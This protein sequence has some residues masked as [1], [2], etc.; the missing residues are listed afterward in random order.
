MYI[1]KLIVLA[2]L[3]V[4]HPS[5]SFAT[6]TDELIEVHSMTT[7][8]INA[9]ATP[10]QE[11]KLVFNAETKKVNVFLDGVWK[12]LLFAFSTDVHLKIAN[13]TLTVLDNESVITFDS[14]SDVIL[15]IPAGLS[16]GFNVS[17][18]QINTGK[19]TIQ[20]ASGVSVLNRL[21]RFRTAGKDAGIGIVSTSQDVFHLTGDLKR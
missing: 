5:I 2:V 20:G 15:T 6:Q 17:V 14:P 16:I 21:N 12:E 4:I 18:Y 13:Y 8:E 11:G 7:S 9:L 3:F 10:I 1:K 19:V